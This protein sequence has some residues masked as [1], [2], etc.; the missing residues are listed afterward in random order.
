MEHRK[1]ETKGNDSPNS[2]LDVVWALHTDVVSWPVWNPDITD[3]TLEQP[4]AA[5]LSF[6]WHTAGLA[7]RSTVCALTDHSRILWGGTVQRIVGTHLWPFVEI[8]GGVLV[9]T[10][11]SWSGEP[12]EANTANLQLG[13]DQSI[14][15]WLQH[16]KTA[17]EARA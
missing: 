1:K 15:S 2:S 12:V 10:E 8:E 13:L 14:V 6:L 16:L 3:V 17:A 5:G 7:I 11:E 4:F 9:S